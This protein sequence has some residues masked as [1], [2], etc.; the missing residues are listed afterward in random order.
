MQKTIALSTAEAE[1]YSASEMAVEIIYLRN[2]IRNMGLQQD[3]DTPVYED[4]TACIEWGNHIIGG[5]ERAKH[6]DIR[7][8][9][10]HEAI[11]NRHMRL[12]RVS[13]DEQFAD[14]FTKALPFPQFAKCLMGLMGG[15]LKPKGP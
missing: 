2:L 13:T 7:K 4:N 11:Q 10:A 12:I 8:H 6:I 9:F 5:R 1:Y 3:D 15:D 14:I